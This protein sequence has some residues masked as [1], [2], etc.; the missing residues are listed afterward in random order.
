MIIDLLPDTDAAEWLET[1]REAK[2][3]QRIVSMLKTRLPNRLVETMAG[4]WFQDVKIG[5]CSPRQLAQLGARLNAWQFRPGGSEGYR[6][7][8]VTLGGID[9]NEVSSKTFEVKKVPGLYAI[10]EALDVTGWLGGYNFQWAWSSGWCAG[11]AAP[12]CGR[13]ARRTTIFHSCC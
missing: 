2:P 5:C 1:E 7:A 11:W 9:T 10:G 13:S 4:D 12:T 6:T 8:E 3:R